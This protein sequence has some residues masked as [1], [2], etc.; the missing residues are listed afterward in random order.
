[1]V[2]IKNLSDIGIEE[3]WTATKKC[4]ILDSRSV[5]YEYDSLLGYGAV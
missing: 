3:L 4:K 2:Y 5:E 1:M